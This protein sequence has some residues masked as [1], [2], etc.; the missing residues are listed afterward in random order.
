VRPLVV[1]GIFA[2]IATASALAQLAYSAAQGRVDVIPTIGNAAFIWMLFG[3]LSL[4][5]IWTARHFPLERANL[6]RTVPAHGVTLAVVSMVHTALYV[7]FARYLLGREGTFTLGEE[8]T[9]ALL[10]NLRGDVFV[11]GAMVGAYYLYA[12]KTGRRTVEVL[13]AP[14]VPPP[15][16]VTRVPLKDDG[17]VSFIDVDDIERIEADGDYVRIHG[18]KEAKLVRQSLTA[19][20]RQLEPARFVRVHR[21]TIVR[22]D[23]IAELQPMFHGEFVA[24]MASGARVKVSRTYRASLTAALGIKA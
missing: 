7:P 15:A 16:F 5:A 1:L 3:V 23:A 22:L 11:Y 14:A 20:E 9:G 12:L 24:V 13:P 4:G 6:V 10:G 18:A 2:A 19:F 17:V 21:S 8:L